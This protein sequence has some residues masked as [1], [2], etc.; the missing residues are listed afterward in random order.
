MLQVIPILVTLRSVHNKDQVQIMLE[1]LTGKKR[2]SSIAIATAGLCYAC[3]HAFGRLAQRQL[4][5]QENCYVLGKVST[6]TLSSSHIDILNTELERFHKPPICSSDEV[7]KFY[8]VVVGKNVFFSK[9]YT[10]VKA[11]NSFTVEYIHQ[12]TVRIGTVL[13]FIY[14]S[15]CTFASISELQK[16]SNISGY[17]GVSTQCL[18]VLHC[19]GVIPVVPVQDSI[20]FVPV[21]KLYKKAVFIQCGVNMY[22]GTFPSSVIDD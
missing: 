14:I 11:R 18:S 2:Y 9:E 21:N 1:T 3:M 5:G 19:S 20:E 4:L 12:G 6:V 15:G 10:R 22:V 17:F 8:R 7:H 13:Y 16:I